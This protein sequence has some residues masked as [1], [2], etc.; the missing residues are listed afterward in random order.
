MVFM[1]K[2]MGADEVLSMTTITVLR[3]FIIKT[4][5]FPWVDFLNGF[6]MLKRQTNKMLVA[7]IGNIIIA[8]ISMAILV[9]FFPYLNGVNGSIAT[10]LGELAGFIVVEIGKRRVGKEC[11]VG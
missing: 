11:R 7:Q 1:E 9:H 4:F 5:I 10:S 3:F 6:L 2:I 8:I